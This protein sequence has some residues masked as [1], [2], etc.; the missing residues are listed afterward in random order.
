M[1]CL[2]EGPEN[3]VNCT[4]NTILRLLLNWQLSIHLSQAQRILHK[5]DDHRASFN[6]DS[7]IAKAFSGYPSSMYKV[8]TRLQL[9]GC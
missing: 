7:A 5:V 6:V 3:R 9:H 4:I 8:N 1:S 2:L